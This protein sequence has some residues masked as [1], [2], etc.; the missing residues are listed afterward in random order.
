MKKIFRFL[1][2]ALLLVA[3]SPS[4]AKSQ[5]DIL[6]SE[7][8]DS[9]HVN[10]ETA[11]EVALQ[12]SPTII[13]ADREITRTHY[14]R[15]EAQ[16]GFWPTIAASGTYNRTLKK[17]VMAMDFGGETMEISVGTDNN[18]AA[19]LNLALPL[20]APALWKTVQLSN[21]DIE[22]AVE[23]A[24][25]SRVTMISSVKKAYF[26][27]LLAKDSYNVLQRNYNN[28]ALN[29]KIVTDKFDQGLASEYDKL[30][31][32][33]QL[34]NQRP[35][36]LAAEAAIELASMQIKALMGVDVDYP[37]I[38]E[39]TLSDY[40]SEVNQESYL[41]NAS[42]SLAQNSALRQMDIQKKQLETALQITRASYMPTLA[43]ASAFQYSSMNNNFKFSTYKWYTYS[44]AALS[45]SIP[46]F[47]GMSKQQKVKQS[48][49]TM[50]TLDDTRLN[51]ERN[52]QISVHGCLVK[53]ENAIAD[54]ASN[55]ENMAMAEKAY[56]ISQK[57]FDVGMTTWLELSSSELAL[58]QA[59][60]A[61]HQS[62]YDYMSYMAELDSVLGKNNT[63]N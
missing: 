54:L 15:K 5:S 43:L 16:S 52:L 30:R 42:F 55:K 19:G 29:T 50:Q 59:R 9:L 24:R 32:E 36:L 22:L 31:A 60:L 28:V 63:N 45:L 8:T 61:Y 1:V 40:E 47:S 14:A 21:L 51:T 4:P 17:Q 37:I 44:N 58:T 27:Y 6:P 48:Q 25:A 12:S 7:P 18:W 10:L 26:A 39:G 62:I 35:A 56:S 11:L 49:L 34:K 20:V 3:A 38:F 23:S 13:I 33:V 46:I 41:Q 2:P 53:M 57:Q